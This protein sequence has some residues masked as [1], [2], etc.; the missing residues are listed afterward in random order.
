MKKAT[1]DMV[2]FAM[3]TV[4]NKWIVMFVLNSIEFSTQEIDTEEEARAIMNRVSERVKEWA[5]GGQVWVEE[6]VDECENDL[7][8]RS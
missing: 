7:Q 5:E 4:N 1:F 8:S 3:S 2:P 6:E